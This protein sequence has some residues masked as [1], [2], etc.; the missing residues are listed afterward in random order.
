M[1]AS[2][3]EE[4]VRKYYAAET[5]LAEEKMLSDLFLSGDYPEEY[6][7]EA[8]QFRYFE[9]SRKE[10]SPPPKFLAHMDKFIAAEEAAELRK[11]NRK[12]K[13]ILA[14]VFAI[15]FLV[16]GAFFSVRHYK[17]NEQTAELKDPQ[18]MYRQTQKFLLIFSGKYSTGIDKTV[19]LG[20]NY[21]S[22]GGSVQTSSNDE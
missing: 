6:W 22:A 21:E 5:S 20:T 9:E 8:M 15:G 10:E 4:L 16:T 11:K 3:I 19:T 13:A 1:K 14:G 2:E 7:A 18:E 17:P 12:R